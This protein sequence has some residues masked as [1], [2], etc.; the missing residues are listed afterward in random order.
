MKIPTPN[1]PFEMKNYKN[2]KERRHCPPQIPPHRGEDTPSPD[3]IL[4]A[5][6]ASTLVP[7][8]GNSHG[9]PQI[10]ETL[11]MQKQDSRVNA[12]IECFL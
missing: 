3:P 1:A 4:G 12:A 5:F 8:M 9:C 6:G 2:F 11:L 7:S 10:V